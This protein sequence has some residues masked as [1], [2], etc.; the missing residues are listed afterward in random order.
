MPRIKDGLDRAVELFA[1][2]L[3]KLALEPLAN[4]RFESI[5]QIL[6]RRRIDVG[7]GRDVQLLLRLV[8][9]LFKVVL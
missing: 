3:R 2:V 6:P 7:I 5:D 8:D 4:D 1:Y 9:G